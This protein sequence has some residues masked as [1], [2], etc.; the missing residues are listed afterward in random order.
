MNNIICS[1]L[2]KNVCILT[3]YC[4]WCFYPKRDNYPQNENCINYNPCDSTGIYCLY[5]YLNESWSQ[6]LKCNY[7]RDFL[8]MTLLALSLLIITIII[9]LYKY[10]LEKNKANKFDLLAKLNQ[11]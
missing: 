3:N 10:Q 6:D 11:I 1:S 2:E 5:G 4:A 9:V 8:I 7:V